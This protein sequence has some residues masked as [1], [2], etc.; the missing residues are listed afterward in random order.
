LTAISL[1]DFDL[2]LWRID[3]TCDAPHV[4]L[5]PDEVERAQ[6]LKIPAAREQF[7]RSRAWMRYLLSLYVDTSPSD[8][9]FVYGEHG[10]PALSS[11]DI[12]FN[13]AHSDNRAVLAVARF[14]V[15]VDIE[16]VR[17]TR[18]DVL[19]SISFTDDE[20]HAVSLEPDLAL[21]FYR[22]WT[23][24]EAV[25]KCLGSG[26]RD[27]VRFSVSAG[28]S[29]FFLSDSDSFFVCLSLHEVFWNDYVCTVATERKISRII[30]RDAC[31]FSPHL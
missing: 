29:L 27:M 16:H 25:V 9:C 14:S 15:G 18:F 31:E 5:S 26:F 8:L 30:V 11:G 20:R 6:R 4:I 21:A 13:L 12:L 24:K 1:P 7:V 10:K 28:D 17:S 23:R 19:M 2:H 22:V 3:L